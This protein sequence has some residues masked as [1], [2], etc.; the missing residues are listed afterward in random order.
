MLRRRFIQRLGTALS[1]AAFW[2][3]ALPS[4]AVASISKQAL[5]DY[6]RPLYVPDGFVEVTAISGL[7]RSVDGFGDKESEIALGIATINIRSV[8][9]IRYRSSSRRIRN[10][11]LRALGMLNQA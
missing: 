10:E 6:P 2:K 4:S 9:T 3:I 5:R 8:L 11:G 7:R 1:T